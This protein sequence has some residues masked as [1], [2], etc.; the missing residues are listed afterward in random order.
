MGKVA[1]NE[2]VKL[3]ATFYNNLGAAL[4]VAGGLVPYFALGR[5]V[6]SVRQIFGESNPPVPN[7]ADFGIPLAMCFFA[8]GL[9]LLFRRKADQIIQGVK[10]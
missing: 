5:F 1:K 9:G 6:P 2:R 8:M 4:I 3:R 7:D 10:G